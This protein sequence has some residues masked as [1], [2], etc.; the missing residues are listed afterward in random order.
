MRCLSQSRGGREC[1]D[2]SAHEGKLRCRQN[3]RGGRL[4]PPPRTYSPKVFD[5][6]GFD[7]D[8]VRKWV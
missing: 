2:E 7:R 1:E 4:S 5:L 6:K 3:T 8:Q